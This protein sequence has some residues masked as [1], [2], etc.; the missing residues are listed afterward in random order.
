MAAWVK[1]FTIFCV[2]SP[3]SY[4][5]HTSTNVPLLRI[6]HSCQTTHLLFYCIDPL[7]YF[8][9]CELKVYESNLFFFF[10]QARRSTDACSVPF[11][12]AR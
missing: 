2:R 5:T 9:F 7:K 6:T 10:I 11:Q 3:I 12:G 1:Q 8:Q 4:Q